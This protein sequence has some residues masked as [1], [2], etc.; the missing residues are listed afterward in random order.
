MLYALCV[1][2]KEGNHMEAQGLRM[3]EHDVHV[4]DG[5]AGRPFDQVV[6]GRHDDQPVPLPIHI[7]SNVT[8]VRSFHVLCVGELPH[9]E[10]PNKRLIPIGFPKG[11]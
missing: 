3:A 10:N 7:Q 9:R 6:D 5:L 8:I 11:I 2:G 4:L 1:S